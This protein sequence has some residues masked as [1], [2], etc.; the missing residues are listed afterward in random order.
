VVI[1]RDKDDPDTTV[2]LLGTGEVLHVMDR[3][4]LGAIFES[5]D[6]QEVQ[7]AEEIDDDG[8]AEREKQYCPG[9]PAEAYGD[10]FG[11]F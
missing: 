1:F 3:V 2:E 11:S 8:D 5:D 6:I 4:S 7:E 10:I 9:A